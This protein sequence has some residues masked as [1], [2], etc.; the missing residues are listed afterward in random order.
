MPSRQDASGEQATRRP[1]AAGAGPR[2]PVLSSVPSPI[3]PPPSAYP[4]SFL[5]RRLAHA[6]G[7]LALAASLVLGAGEAAAE[8]VHAIAMH[9]KPKHPPGF[10]HF[11]YV[12]P[13][14]PRGGRL[15]LGQQ[16]TF[17]SLN[18][19]VV[20]G[21]AASGLRNYVYESLLARSGDE[22]FTLYGLIAES[23]EVPPDRSFATFH[24]RPEAR[25][26]DGQPITPDDVLY[27]HAFLKDR[28]YPF[29]REHYRKVVAA[30]KIGERSVRFTFNA[31]GN[32]PGMPGAM[33]RAMRRP[34]ARC[35]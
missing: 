18:P 24:L 35:R 13:D 22:P 34:T 20:K 21:R 10:S 3:R 9:G 1:V 8:P 5:A 33:R 27:S 29:H 32:A 23:I 11:P 15:V 17:D 7:A 16:G 25:F 12:N 31:P 6:L 19:F 26:A 28:G 4:G 2:Y 30:E 14:A